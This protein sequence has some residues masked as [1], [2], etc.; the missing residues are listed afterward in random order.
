MRYVVLVP[1][2][3]RYGQTLSV[4]IGAWGTQ[5]TIPRGDFSSRQFVCRRVPTP[6]NNAGQMRGRPRGAAP[7]SVLPAEGH[8]REIEPAV[9]AVRRIARKRECVRAI[10]IRHAAGRRRDF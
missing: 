9:E 8:A 3:R 6:S 7:V 2:K 10:E 5:F 1:T 4:A